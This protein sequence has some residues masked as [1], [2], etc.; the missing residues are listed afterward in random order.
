MRFIIYRT[1]IT[2]WPRDVKRCLQV[3]YVSFSREGPPDTLFI[4]MD[5]GK[6]GRRKEEKCKP[7]F[8]VLQP[9]LIPAYYL[10]V[11]S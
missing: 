5:V 6:V 9:I 1:K 10:Q 7:D 8:A 4:K 11:Y 2:V 3:G